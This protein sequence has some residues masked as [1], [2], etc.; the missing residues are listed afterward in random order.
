MFAS[1]TGISTSHNLHIVLNKGEERT[2]RVLLRPLETG[3]L[4]WRFFFSN[5]VDSTWADGDE[6]Y[7][8]MP[9]GRFEIVSCAV[10]S[11]HDDACI[12]SALTPVVWPQK[13]V[14]PRMTLYSE[15]VDVAIEENGY[16]V[17]SWCVRALEDG[18]RLPITPDSQAL[19]YTAVGDHSFDGAAAFTADQ[20]VM[21]P[22]QF[23]ADRNVRAQ[24][25][26]MGDSITQGCGTRV[27]Y[28]EQWATRIAMGIDKDIA[29]WN[30]G[31]GYG[32]GA[33]AAQ[34]GAWLAKAKQ[35]DIVNLCFGVNDIFRGC[36]P[37]L[38][39]NLRKTVR[40]LHESPR[41]PRVV[42]LT[43]PPFDMVETD[44]ARWR[45]VVSCIREDGLGADAVFD[46][47]AM[48]CQPAPRDN[49]AAFSP[50]PDGRGGATAA[51]EYLSHFWPRHRKMLLGTQA[52]KI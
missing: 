44:E 31:L 41:H 52:K 49:Y 20:N 18:C 9:G 42:L 43:I 23:A 37:Q 21:L 6:S 30:I 47:A 2:F 24:M 16:I 4:T 48:L 36:G 40:L 45:E 29:V 17:F 19:C 10:G 51:G 46:I 39:D 28:Y 38:I 11:A 26:F 8:N 1:N 14:E 25:V 27:N 5:S 3:T 50:H 12:A 15:P 32:R 13:I 34:D 22:D 35:A 33:D 7:A